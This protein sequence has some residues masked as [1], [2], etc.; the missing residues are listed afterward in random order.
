MQLQCHGRHDQRGNTDRNVDEE[1][2]FPAEVVGEP[3]T[4]QRAG[5]R[6]DAEDSGEH[7]LVLASLPGWDHV[8]DDGQSKGHQATAAEALDGTAGDHDVDSGDVEEIGNLRRE[9][10]DQGADRERQRSLPGT[11]AAARVCRR[12]CPRAAWRQSRSADTP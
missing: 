9:A 2:P 1:D 5:H 3:A 10:A 6:G 11:S 4:Q 7:S 8:T 12:S